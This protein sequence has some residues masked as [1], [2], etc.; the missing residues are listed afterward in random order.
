MERKEATAVEMG[1]AFRN[2]PEGTEE[3]NIKIS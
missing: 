1:A 3:N 2:T